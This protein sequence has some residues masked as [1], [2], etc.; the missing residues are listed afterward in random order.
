VTRGRIA[1][2]CA[3]AGLTMVAGS[4]VFNV[5]E[6]I[7]YNNCKPPVDPYWPEW[8]GAPRIAYGLAFLAIPSG[9]RLV[10]TY[11]LARREA[12]VQ[13]LGNVWLVRVCVHG[14]D[15]VSPARYRFLTW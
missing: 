2:V 11:L 15:V 8:C 13:S 5:I 4:L 7:I 3:V 1:L 10:A 12:I 6:E 14:V 9:P